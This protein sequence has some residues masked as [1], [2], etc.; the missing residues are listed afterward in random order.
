MAGQ[1]QLAGLIEE[2][3][4]KLCTVRAMAANA[5]PFLYGL[6]YDLGIFSFGHEVLM[7]LQTEFRRWKHLLHR[8]ITG[9]GVV[10]ALAFP[11]HKRRVT[12]AFYTYILHFY[13]TGETNISLGMLEERLIIR[14]V[15]LMTSC[16]IL[17][18]YGRMNVCLIKFISGLLMTAVAQGFRGYA[19]HSL[20][21][22][23]MG[24]VAG[25][26]LICC[27]GFMYISCV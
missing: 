27:E 14:S 15:R 2:Q 17:F 16:T 9:M 12:L 19:Q 8:I 25:R 5:V 23:S 4:G 11:S 10:T 6:M 22:G 3:T 18:T 26:A 24:V 21:I 13:M 20:I 7:T 1:T